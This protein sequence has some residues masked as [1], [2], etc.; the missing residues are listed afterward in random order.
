MPII[1]KVGRRSKKIR[2]INTAIHVVL[3]LGAVTM[4]YPF[5]MMVSA[6]FKSHVD[7][8]KFSVYPRFFLNEEVLYKK[9][10]EARYNEESNQMLEN[11]K[12]R[13][14]SF[15]QTGIPEKQVR[16]IY[17]D[18]QQFLQENGAEHNLY[19]FYIS[20]QFGRGIYPRNERIFRQL[21]KQESE[22][23]LQN[24]NR[25]YN[26][27]VLSWDEVRVE[28][29]DILS[30][31]ITGDYKGF[32]KRYEEF[33]SELSYWNRVYCTLDGNF[34][35]NELMPA[36]RS[37]LEQMNKALGTDFKSWDEI[38]LSPV[39]PQNSLAE[40]WENYV[41][42]QLNIHHVNVLPQAENLYL[43]FLKQKYGE[44]GLL[45]KTYKTFYQ[46]FAEIKLPKD[47]PGSGAVLVDWIYFIENFVPVEFLTVK[48]VE[49]DY[50]NWLSRKYASIEDLNDQYEKGYDSLQEVPLAEQFP[51]GNLALQKDW[52]EFVRGQSDSG[53]VGLLM[54]S[55]AEYLEFLKG[56]L[57][58]FE[59]G[60]GQTEYNNISGRKYTSIMNIYPSAKLPDEGEYSDLWLR[61]VKNYV[62]GRFLTVYSAEEQAN[63]HSFLKEKYGSAAG[64]NES[65]HLTYDNFS[66]V[67]L[68]SYTIDYFVF[69]EHQKSIFW[70][71]VK[72]NY[73]MVLDLMLI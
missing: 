6:S 8:V 67:E 50:R 16:Q 40:H 64:L 68:D 11:Y 34:I 22:G 41:K 59:G 28:E 46:S 44:I 23:E 56:E 20:E 1:G 47:L 37:D 14:I 69:K 36:Y 9:Y 61:F 35:K 55:Q 62:S 2:V 15:E 25:R 10:I 43:E 70:E 29:R 57:T 39:V 73:V 65:Y 5:M 72:R 27:S 7:S 53:N 26:T 21:I 33:R 42:Y 54:T 32:L 45:N 17:D 66:Q 51:A 4:I 71:F 19:D 30:R 12:G 52:T 24:F 48:S 31:N 60:S 63:W 3:L 49:L 13:F 38:Q 58:D 18:W